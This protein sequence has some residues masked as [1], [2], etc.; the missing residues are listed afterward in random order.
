M[1]GDEKRKRRG[2]PLAM[3]GI[4][5]VA[6]IGG[7]AMLWESPFPA[8]PISLP[9]SMEMLAQ[10][11][12]DAPQMGRTRE[13]PR[14]PSVGSDAIASL[15]NTRL[16]GLATGYLLDAANGRPPVSG[17]ANIL[18]SADRPYSVSPQI[19]AGHQLLWAAALAHIPMPSA[20]ENAW[21]ARGK[22]EEPVATNV[23]EQGRSLLV[24]TS[25]KT[26][27]QRLDRWSLDAWS[28]WR[29]GSNA[30]AISQGRVPI[31]GASQ[32]GA[33]LRYR[34]DPASANDPM[35]H[36]RVYHALVSGG[37][38]EFAAG[39][40]VR[41]VARLPVRA[42]AELRR[43]ENAFGSQ[44]RPA[45][46]AA[47]ELP[48]VSLPVGLTAEAYGQAGYVGGD[49]STAFADGQVIVS[50]EVASFDLLSVSPARVSVGA[51]VWGGAQEDATRLDL[52]PTVRLDLSIGNVP[53]RVSVDWREQVAGDASP[54]SGIAA[55]LSTRF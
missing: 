45:V 44:L 1:I 46:F 4:L 10:D 9:E 34:L 42:F 41:P 13:G 21:R 35:L 17:A 7:R 6:W 24:E 27:K 22:Q 26:G 49:N 43:S 40:A 30:S 5:A 47:T 8:N 29:E 31:Y 38:T 15:A 19:A 14:S 20:V 16:A 3:L 36:G 50:G 32:I 51:G 48:Q 23:F 54:G 52:G 2:G 39:F 12:G 18:S 53:A 11:G 28:F 37:E 25:T 33:S 55:T